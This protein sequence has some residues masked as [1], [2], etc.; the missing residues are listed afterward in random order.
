MTAVAN[1]G[2]RI[3][4][5]ATPVW[6]W[7]RLRRATEGTLSYRSA[8]GAASLAVGYT[9]TDRQIVIPIAAYDG[10]AHLAIDTEVTLGLTGHDEDGLRWVV[11]ASGIAGLAIAS[12]GSTGLAACRQSHPAH[13]AP[14]P[15]NEALLLP[16]ARLRG[17]YETSLHTND[18]ADVL[19]DD[20]PG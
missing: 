10:R 11:R 16:I 18:D 14:S 4:D 19:D 8:R 7:A 15:A 2:S 20:N 9:L 5:L 1:S 13:G 17:F 12:S 3:I 6:C